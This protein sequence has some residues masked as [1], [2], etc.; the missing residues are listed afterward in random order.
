MSTSTTSTPVAIANSS[1]EN[2][3]EENVIENT[4]EENDDDNEVDELMDAEE[5]ATQCKGGWRNRKS[6][7]FW[8][9]G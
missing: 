7:G 5:V 3:D 4:D 2:T 9:L 6:D 1:I 8:N